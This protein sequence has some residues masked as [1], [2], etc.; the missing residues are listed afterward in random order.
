M[1]ADSLVYPLLGE[2]AYFNDPKKFECRGFSTIERDDIEKIQESCLKSD[3]VA[4]TVVSRLSYLESKTIL[5]PIESEQ[6]SALRTAIR[7]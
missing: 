2:M 5:S 6:M 1:R 3:D 7:S 4:R